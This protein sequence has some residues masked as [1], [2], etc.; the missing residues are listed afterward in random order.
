MCASYV[1]SK[2]LHFEYVEHIRNALLRIGDIVDPNNGSVDLDDDTTSTTTRANRR[3]IE[4]QLVS[5]NQT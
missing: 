5:E 4:S 3:R 1:Q 2:I